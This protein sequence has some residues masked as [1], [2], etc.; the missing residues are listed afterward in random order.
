MSA[1]MKPMEPM[2][3]G[4][5]N[6]HWTVLQIILQIL[7]QSFALLIVLQHRQPMRMTSPKNASNNVQVTYLPIIPLIPVYRNAHR[8]LGTSDF[9]INVLRLVQKDFM[10]TTKPDY[11][12]NHGTVILTPMAIPLLRPV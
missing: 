11:V 7:S 6:S 1:Q 8:I 2:I 3:Q 5:V 12:F 10:Q 9:K 4:Y